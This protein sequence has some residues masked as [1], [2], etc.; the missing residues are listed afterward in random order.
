[1]YIKNYLIESKFYDY[2][3]SAKNLYWISVCIEAIKFSYLCTYTERIYIT[4][5]II[6]YKIR[7]ITV[8]THTH[9]SLPALFNNLE[10]SVDNFIDGL[11]V[12]I[13]ARW[14]LDSTRWLLESARWLLDSARKVALY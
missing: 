11:I 8:I 1:M 3:L 6:I 12:E 7:L 4:K 9:T 13:F 10:I 2:S 5:I 14:R